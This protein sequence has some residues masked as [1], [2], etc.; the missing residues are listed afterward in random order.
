VAAINPQKISGNWCS[1]IALDFHTISSTPIGVNQ[2]GHTV[3][4]TVRPELGELL[5]RLKYRAD[6]SAADEIIATAARFLMPHRARFDLIVPVPPP[7]VR[8]VQ[9][10]ILMADGIGATIG[11]P[12]VQCVKATRATEQLKNVDD[13]DKR[14]ELLDGLY[15]VD[16]ACTA[17]KTSC[18]SMTCSGPARP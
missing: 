12:V 9:P 16:A 11:V 14:K 7:T 17:G 13:P 15:T 2:Y 1:G 10:V 8:A 18:C 3:F 5:H 6:Q 4:D